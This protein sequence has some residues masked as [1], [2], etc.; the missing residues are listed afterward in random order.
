M[1]L[2][3]SVGHMRDP[4]EVPR[5]VPSAVIGVSN[6]VGLSY[7]DSYLRVAIFKIQKERSQ[8]K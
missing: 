5:C 1:V 2:S 6:S 3:D 4:V 7:A 8:A